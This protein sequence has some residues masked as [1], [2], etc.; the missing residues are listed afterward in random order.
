M[1]PLFWLQRIFEA[2]I[3]LCILPSVLLADGLLLLVEF[4]G[5]RPPLSTRMAVLMS[6]LISLVCCF[7]RGWVHTCYSWFAD[8]L[9]PCIE[10]GFSENALLKHSFD[11]NIVCYQILDLWSALFGLCWQ[12]CQSLVALLRVLSVLTSFAYGHPL[13]CCCALCITLAALK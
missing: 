10:H 6:A 7:N 1:L 9:Q 4:L 3:A 12:I 13:F 5:I 11:T 2:F 8:Q